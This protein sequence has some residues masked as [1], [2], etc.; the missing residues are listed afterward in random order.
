[1]PSRV[2][3]S[4]WL[5]CW[6]ENKQRQRAVVVSRRIITGGQC[7]KCLYVAGEIS[8]KVFHSDDRVETRFVLAGSMVAVVVVEQVFDGGREFQILHRAPASA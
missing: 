2:A 7:H 6:H 3:L 8:P 5:S 1:M 4:T